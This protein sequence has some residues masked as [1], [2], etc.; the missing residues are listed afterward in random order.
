MRGSPRLAH[1]EVQS[2]CNGNSPRDLHVDLLV[3]AS[4]QVSYSENRRL[5][6]VNSHTD[7]GEDTWKRILLRCNQPAHVLDSSAEEASE[8][9]RQKTP[10]SEICGGRNS[11]NLNLPARGQC[12][13]YQKRQEQYMPVCHLLPPFVEYRQ[14]VR[15]ARACS[16]GCGLIVHGGGRSVTGHLGPKR[17]SGSLGSKCPVTWIKSRYA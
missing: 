5:S 9:P 7:T 15:V 6:A 10:D 11:Q 1:L 17:P 4:R 2:G 14:P 12:R 3:G 16:N 13:G 8:A